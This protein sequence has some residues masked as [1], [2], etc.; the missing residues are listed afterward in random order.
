MTDKS[1]L[2][3]SSY[4]SYGGGFTRYSRLMKE[5]SSFFN[6]HMSFTPFFSFSLKSSI[7]DSNYSNIIPN[8]LE[9]IYY[10]MT[11]QNWVVRNYWEHKWMFSFLILN[12]ENK[13]GSKGITKN[14]AEWVSWCFVYET[15][16]IDIRYH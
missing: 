15:E 16:I 11:Y 6:S 5:L 2:S 8:L 10:R 13:R 4:W 12:H 14:W 7:Y 3:W 9:E 1:Y